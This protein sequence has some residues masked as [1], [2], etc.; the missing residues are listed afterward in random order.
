M[1]A[2]FYL[3]ENDY[4]TFEEIDIACENGIG[5]KMGPF[6]TLDLTGVD[7]A[8][9]I[10]DEHLKKTGEKALGYDMLKELTEAGRYGTKT[11]K[12]FYEYE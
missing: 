10:R 2:A 9:T 6:K 11:G 7:L 5:H 3:V 1:D 12:G 8:Y 4:C